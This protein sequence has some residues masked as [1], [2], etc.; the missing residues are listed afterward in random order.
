MV[1]ILTGLG[2]F[3]LKA[4]DAQ[5]ALAVLGSGVHIELLLRD[6]VMPGPVLSTDMARQAVQMLPDLRVLFTSGYTQNAIVHGGRFDP[7]VELL[8]KPYSREQLAQRIR[9]LLGPGDPPR[10]MVLDVGGKAPE[11]TS[12]ASSGVGAAKGSRR[13][14]RSRIARSGL[15]TACHDGASAY[16]S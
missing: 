13:G 16:E 6:V 9:Q 10:E 4:A 8:S 15:R 3:V 7:G 2:Y 14:G 11:T 12:R 5:Q 1:D